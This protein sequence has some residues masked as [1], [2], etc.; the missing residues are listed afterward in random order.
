MT[1]CML[2][3]KT[4]MLNLVRTTRF[5]KILSPGKLKIKRLENQ[6]ILTNGIRKQEH[7]K[8]LDMIAKIRK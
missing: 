8:D 5:W 4:L 6:I 1:L 7:L 3:Y 2:E